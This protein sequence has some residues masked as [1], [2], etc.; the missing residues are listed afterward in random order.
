[1]PAN[2]PYP[3]ETQATFKRRT[4]RGAPA[5]ADFATQFRNKL[6]GL[7]RGALQSRL[8]KR[9]KALPTSDQ[10]K[11]AGHDIKAVDILKRRIALSQS[12]GAR[13]EALGA[14]G[15]E[16]LRS[17]PGSKEAK[18]AALRKKRNLALSGAP[19]G[20]PGN[21]PPTQTDPRAP[22]TK[23]RRNTMG[24]SSYDV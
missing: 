1:M 20:K 23:R 22:V 11:P 17:A 5:N 13:K 15:I 12:P 6:R 14:K 7:D 9:Q 18:A 16:F 21:T 2:S 24:R 19:V 3:N 8:E 10:S 4:K